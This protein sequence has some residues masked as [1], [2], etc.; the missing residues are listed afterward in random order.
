MTSLLTIPAPEEHAAIRPLTR[1]VARAIARK[2]QSCRYCG[3]PVVDPANAVLA[4]GATTHRVCA[5]RINE[6]VDQI[7]E[8]AVAERLERLGIKVGR[9]K[10]EIPG[11]AV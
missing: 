3:D 9:N 4:N 10:I 7:N 5:D 2:H 6:I 1:Q 11:R 8:N